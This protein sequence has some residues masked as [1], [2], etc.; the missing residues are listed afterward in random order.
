MARN[1]LEE[2]EVTAITRRRGRPPAH[3]AGQVVYRIIKAATALFLEQG[4]GRTTLDQVA[5][6]AKTGK[7]S[8][9]GHFHNKQVLFAAVV[10]STIE[11]MFAELPEVSAHAS[12][13]DALRDMGIAL[14]ECLL[15]PQCVALMRV[16]AA[17]A[18]NMPDIAKSTYQLGFND[19]S[20]RIKAM[21]DAGRATKGRETG[22]IAHRF[23]EVALQP[24]F[25]QAVFGADIAALRA[26]A[27]ADID[28]AIV[29]LK[30]RGLLA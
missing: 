27:A 24:I 9:Y 23:I 29:L 14:V 15:V 4:F 21:L 10:R 19:A 13:D 1:E 7:S 18:T 22:A 16:T 8:L 2:P 25:F 12:N 3:E 30:T 20:T 26:R 5:A 28:D 17:E 6:R 11:R